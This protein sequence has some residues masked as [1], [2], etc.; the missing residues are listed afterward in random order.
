MEAELG[1]VENK[2]IS[3]K[4]IRYE[5]QIG[6]RLSDLDLYGHVNAKHYLDLVVSS[7]TQFLLKRFGISMEA[8]AA[9]GIGFFLNKATTNFK[10]PITGLQTVKVSSHVREIGKDGRLFV[11]PFQITQTDDDAKVFCEGELEVTVIDMKTLRSTSAP[12]WVL[13][14][15][16]Q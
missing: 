1:L 5:E 2:V 8:I 6:I 14:F 10:R 7:R 16:F 15:L 9:Q 11:I 12:E 4:P 3:R 13:D